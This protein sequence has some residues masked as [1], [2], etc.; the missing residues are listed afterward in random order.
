MLEKMK[1]SMILAAMLLG[2]AA[3]SAQDTE[4]RLGTVSYC[5]PSTTLSFE[6]DALCEIYH[7]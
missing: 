6:V 2:S 1:K 7:V 5:L 4:T 3:V